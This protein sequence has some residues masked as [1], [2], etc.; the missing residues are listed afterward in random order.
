[1]QNTLKHKMPFSSHLLVT[2]Q[3]RKKATKFPLLLFRA[4]RVCVSWGISIWLYR[5]S[6]LKT[7]AVFHP[8][9][10]V[11]TVFAVPGK[12]T[13]KIGDAENRWRGYW[14]QNRLKRAKISPIQ[15][16]LSTLKSEVW[17][18]VYK[19]PKYASKVKKKKKRTMSVLRD[20]LSRF[21]SE[22]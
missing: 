8:A 22:G 9:G 13:V 18:Y 15:S 1:M 5:P 3:S 12:V 6:P 20:R 14:Y 4:N 10:V 17:N 11:I 16:I 21:R 19:M 2:C 7:Q